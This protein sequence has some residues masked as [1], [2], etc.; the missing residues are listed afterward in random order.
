MEKILQLHI[1]H[2]AHYKILHTQ[3]HNTYC[4]LHILH[5]PCGKTHG[6]IAQS[7]RPQTALFNSLIE[8]GTSEFLNRFSLQW[9][10]LYRLPEGKSSKW[11]F[12]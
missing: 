6:N 1:V 2:I 4:T 8:V 5:T 3:I 9:G 7:L 11:T 10:T 12:Q